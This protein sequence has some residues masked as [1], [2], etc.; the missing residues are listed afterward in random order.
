MW[1]R[2]RQRVEYDVDIAGHQRGDGGGHATIRHVN[3]L[4]AGHH[5]EQLAG[6]MTEVSAAARAHVDLAGIGLRMGDEFG[7]RSDRQRR[8]DH[9]RKGIVVDARDGDNVAHDVD[10]ELFVE[11]H[12]DGMRCRNE[13]KRMPVRWSAC[14]GLQGEITAAA[15]PVLDHNRLTEPLRQRLCNEPRNDVRR[16]AGRHEDR[17]GHRPRRI[18]LRPAGARPCRQRTGRC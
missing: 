15:G 16:A 4:G 18:A 12:I 9:H 7:N 13:Q 2:R 10:I 5:L 6:Q 1:Q 8:I 11:R 3:H 17:Q 14:D